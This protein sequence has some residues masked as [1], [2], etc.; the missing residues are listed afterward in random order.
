MTKQYLYDKFDKN[1]VKSIFY[2]EIVHWLRLMPYKI[3]KNGERSVLFYAGL[4]KV[5]NDVIKEFEKNEKNSNFWFR[6]YII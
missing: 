5:L 3:E 1:K 6:W 4:I 2:H